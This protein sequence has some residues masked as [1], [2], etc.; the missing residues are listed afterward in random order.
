MDA[1]VMASLPASDLERA[2]A[3]YA[4]KLGL[5]PTDLSDEGSLIYQMTDGS[6]F[7][8]YE[9][10]FAGTNQATAAGLAVKDFD[11]AIAELRTAGVTFDE[12]D[13]GE[14]MATEDGILTAPE[15]NRIAWF[16]DSEGNIIGVTQDIRP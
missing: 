7:M 10:A 8:V 16:R 13:L 5:T 6:G 15:G 3:W 11:A 1:T 14:G 12:V 2:K 9:S 4:D